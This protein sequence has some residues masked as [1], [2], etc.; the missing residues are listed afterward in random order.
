M[1]AK[2]FIQLLE[3]TKTFAPKEK[4]SS[5]KP[6]AK[7]EFDPRDID[8]LSLIQ[9][10]IREAQETQRFLEEFVKLHKKDEKKEE[11]KDEKKHSE[12]SVLAL[13]ALMYTMTPVM[14]FFFAWMFGL[15]H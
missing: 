15:H 5:R 13:A 10:K 14:G 8:A 1:N 9:L 7:T 4:K 2:D 12:M 11:K 6:K 3:Y